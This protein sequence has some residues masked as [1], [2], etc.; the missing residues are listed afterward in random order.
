MLQM[1]VS[2]GSDIKPENIMLRHPRVSWVEKD[3]YLSSLDCYHVMTPKQLA[4]YYELALIDF[5]TCQM[6]DIPY[7][8]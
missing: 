4:L 5:D 6:T 2:F 1:C 8:S 7:V 3:A